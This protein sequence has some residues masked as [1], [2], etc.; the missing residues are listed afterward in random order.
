MPIR[1]PDLIEDLERFRTELED[2]ERLWADSLGSP[3]PDYPVRNIDELRKQSSRLARILGRLRPYLDR[4]RDTWAMHH[5]ATGVTWDALEAAVGLTMVAQA[6]GPAIRATKDA[7]DQILG[8]LEGM[9]A[10]DVVYA[11]GEEREEQQSPT[12]PEPQPQPVTTLDRISVRELFA[13]LGRLSVGAWITLACILIA[14]LGGV[15]GITRARYEHLLDRRDE[16]LASLQAEVD[17]MRHL[18]AQ[19]QSAPAPGWLQ[20]LKDMAK[21]GQPVD[22][23][24]PPEWYQNPPEDDD[25]FLYRVGSGSL[26]LVDA[27]DHLAKMQVYGEFARYFGVSN[28]VVGDGSYGVD[29]ARSD[30]TLFEGIQFVKND[31]QVVDAGL[32]FRGDGSTYRDIN[33]LVYVLARLPR[34][35]NR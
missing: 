24:V 28:P 26:H 8:R 33:Y 7:V 20:D 11:V 32:Q 27:A 31:V 9:N 3:I 23:P 4:L 16:Q 25:Q 17:S 6:K 21:T 29:S 30:F 19:H 35:P 10:D 15:M 2:H 18:S 14:L 13:A 12:P 34:K 22:G 1:V 5:P